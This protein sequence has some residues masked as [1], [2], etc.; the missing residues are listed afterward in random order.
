MQKVHLL[1]LPICLASC[2]SAP[3]LEET[4]DSYRG[5]EES[6]ILKVFGQPNETYVDEKGLRVLSFGERGALKY[7][8]CVANFVINEESLV[9]RWNWNGRHCQAFTDR[10]DAFAG[11]HSKPL[12]KQP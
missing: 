3:V 4:M 5:V 6:Q 12:P 2:V 8:D 7:P 9:Q 1:V 10:N 11:V